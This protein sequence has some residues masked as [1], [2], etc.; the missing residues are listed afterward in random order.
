M[1]AQLATVGDPALAA[2][3]AAHFR[4]LLAVVVVQD[5]DA[6]GRLVGALRECEGAAVPDILCLTHAAPYR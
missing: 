3:L 2:I 6:R 1:M 5:S 4:G